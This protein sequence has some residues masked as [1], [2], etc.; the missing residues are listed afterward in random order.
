MGQVGCRVAL[1]VGVM[2][3]GGFSLFA[4]DGAAKPLDIE[5]VLKNWHEKIS[6]Y[7]GLKGTFVRTTYDNVFHIQKLSKGTFNVNRSGEAVY[8]WDGMG[9]ENVR[10]KTGKDGSPYSASPDRDEA[11]Y[12]VDSTLIQVNKSDRIYDR[13]EIPKDVSDKPVE[14]FFG[15][16]SYASIWKEFW[17]SRPYLLGM[18]LEELQQRYQISIE[19]QTEEQ[20]WLRFVPKADSDRTFFS[21]SI[22]VLN[23]KTYLPYALKTLDPPGTRETVHLFSNVEGMKELERIP[24]PDLKGYT[25]SS[26]SIKPKRRKPVKK[27]IIVIPDQSETPMESDPFEI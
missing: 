27:D 17:L 24:E 7:Q 3:L 21:E 12:W 19:K 16:K 14:A 25:L 23:L 11:W 9:P 22:L 20:V 4:D 15:F 8:S 5:A 13:I 1:I 6:Q 26:T 18:P 10:R 2:C